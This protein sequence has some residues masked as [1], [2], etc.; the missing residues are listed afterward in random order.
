MDTRPSRAVPPTSRG[1]GLRDSCRKLAWDLG[2]IAERGPNVL[3][4]HV[5]TLAVAERCRWNDCA[6]QLLKPQAASRT[7]GTVYAR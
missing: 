2:E 3:R 7:E 6:M 4:G 1:E 5:F